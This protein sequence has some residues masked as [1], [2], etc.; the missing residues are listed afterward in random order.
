VKRRNLLRGG[1]IAGLTALSGCLSS[2]PLQAEATFTYTPPS[3]VV[4]EKVVFDASESTASE[5]EWFFDK[6]PGLVNFDAEGAKVTHAFEESGA[7][8]VTLRTTAPFGI[9]PGLNMDRTTKT[10]YVEERE[11]SSRDTENPISTSTDRISL[12][13]RGVATRISTDETAVL[14]FS[15]VNLNPDERLSIRLVLKVPSGMS[16]RGT[17]LA[18]SGTGQYAATFNLAPGESAGTS[19]RLAATRTGHFEVEGVANYSFDD[20]D[21]QTRRGTIPIIVAE[22]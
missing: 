2:N 21:E 3:P 20:G 11:Q 14:Q 18:E 6:S 16:L 9:I 8:T 13:L 1:A 12:H 15:A 5:W 10:V 17:S 7:H 19:I 4:G 22:S